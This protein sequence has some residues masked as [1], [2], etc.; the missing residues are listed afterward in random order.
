MVNTEAYI[1]DK[2]KLMYSLVNRQTDATTHHRNKKTLIF[3][4]WSVE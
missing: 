1:H 4:I 2:L 3:C